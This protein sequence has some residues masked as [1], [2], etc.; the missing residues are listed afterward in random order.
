MRRPLLHALVMLGASACTGKPASEARSP[1]RNASLIQ[2]R[3]V[4]DNPGPELQRV[5][6][7][8]DTLYLD[9]RL[10]VSDSDFQAVHPTVRGD[11]LLLQ[12]DVT[13]QGAR[14]LEQLTGQHMGQRLAFLLE[15]HVCSAS[16]IRDT[17]GRAG[18]RIPLTGVC[19]LPEAEANRITEAIRA[20][21]PAATGRIE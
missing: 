21:W 7:G 19:D 13:P 10:A 4:H 17:L 12:I 18:G 1:D 20:R 11:Q 2:L 8:G 16:T 15:S 3:L 6:Y 14:R 5:Q 9:S